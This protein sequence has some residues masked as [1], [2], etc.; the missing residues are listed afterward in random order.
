MIPNTASAAGA[1]HR[2][3]AHRWAASDW[4]WFMKILAGLVV[5]SGLFL[6]GCCRDTV[7]E[8]SGLYVEENW[9]RNLEQRD[10]ARDLLHLFRANTS[11]PDWHKLE[12][13]PELILVDD[14]RLEIEKVSP[15][16]GKLR[17]EADGY[18]GLIERV[19]EERGR[20]SV[21]VTYL[22]GKQRRYLFRAIEP[23]FAR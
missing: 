17:F 8:F 1:A 12:I 18:R 4:E 23:R 21:V 5:V 20:L 11:L 13:F 19:P 14:G 2:W 3:L 10:A 9:Y 22:S 16:Q 15:I 6:S 7:G